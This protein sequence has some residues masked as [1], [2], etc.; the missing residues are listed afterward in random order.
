MPIGCNRKPRKGEAGILLLGIL[1][2]RDTKGA[3]CGRQQGVL[4]PIVSFFEGTR[5][6]LSFKGETTRN[7]IRF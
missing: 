5:C 1:L 6:V 3:L 2:L 7:K 4:N